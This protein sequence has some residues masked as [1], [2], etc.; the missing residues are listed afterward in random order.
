MDCSTREPGRL[1]D[2][3]RPPEVPSDP[4]FA[5]EAATLHVYSKEPASIGDQL[6]AYWRAQGGLADAKVSR[7][8][9]SIKADV[10]RESAMCALKVRVYSVNKPGSYAV[11]FQ[12][13]AG[14]TVLF[15]TIYQHTRQHL[16]QWFSLLPGAHRAPEG[17]QALLGV[18]PAETRERKRTGATDSLLRPLLEMANAKESPSLQAEAAAVLAGLAS[19]PGAARSLCA[20]GA[21]EASLKLLRS[22]DLEVLYPAAR[23]LRTLAQC[24]EGVP[25]FAGS[26]LLLVVLCKVCSSTTTSAVRQEL[27]AALSAELWT[28]WAGLSGLFGVLRRPAQN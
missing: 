13:R 3:P 23:M 2:D 24:P 4:F 21:C 20:A 1:S 12:R 18:A 27:A 10:F 11:E 28:C 7:R 14:D 22:D 25:C 16:Q 6:L 19:E 17:A 5:L 8:K 15:N 9:F 26:G